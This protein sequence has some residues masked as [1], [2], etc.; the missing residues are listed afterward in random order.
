[1]TIV[2]VV[3]IL[4]LILVLFV[5]IVIT[6]DEGKRG[7]RRVPLKAAVDE[8]LHMIDDLTVNKVLVLKHTG[9]V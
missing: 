7:G 6:C 1:L 2:A 5:Q 4:V 9:G 3:V 8:A